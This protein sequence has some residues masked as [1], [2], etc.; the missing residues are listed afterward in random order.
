[1]LAQ[2]RVN[3]IIRD[4]RRRNPGITR[5]M[6]YTSV[7]DKP[8]YPAFAIYDHIAVYVLEDNKTYYGVAAKKLYGGWAYGPSR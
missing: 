2:N 7:R 5:I 1:M 3:R 4:V 8:M 6:F